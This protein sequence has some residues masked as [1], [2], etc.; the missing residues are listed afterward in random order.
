MPSE[1]LKTGNTFDLEVMD[2][3]LSYERFR[4]NGKESIIPDLSP[5]VMMAA[6]AKVKEK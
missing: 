4:S 2:I 6:I 1:V 3:A 5:D